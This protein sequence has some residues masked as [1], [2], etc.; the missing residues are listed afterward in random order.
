MLV[1]GRL[2][3]PKAVVGKPEVNATSASRA[4][5]RNAGVTLVKRPDPTA[6]NGFGH[7]TL[8]LQLVIVSPNAEKAP[9]G[10][11]RGEEPPKGPGSEIQL[12]RETVEGDTQELPCGARK[13]NIQEARREAPRSVRCLECHLLDR[14][15]TCQ[16]HPMKLPR[17]LQLTKHNMEAMGPPSLKAPRGA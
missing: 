17:G 8:S 10:A 14:Q 16:S 15:P 13:I 5:G 2:I 9:E 6:A 11:N 1:V 12:S 3:S 7:C 4:C